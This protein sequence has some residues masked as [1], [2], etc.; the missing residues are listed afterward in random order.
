MLIIDF[1]V[2]GP[3]EQIIDRNIKIIGDFY[4][5]LVFAKFFIEFNNFFA[6]SLMAFVT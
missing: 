4:K 6:Q 2:I 5:F 3:P 1:R